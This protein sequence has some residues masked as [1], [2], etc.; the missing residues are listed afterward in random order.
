MSECITDRAPLQSEIDDHEAGYA[1]IKQIGYRKEVCLKVKMVSGFIMRCYPPGED[2]GYNRQIIAW[3][4][5]PR[6]YDAVAEAKETAEL[7]V[8]MRSGSDEKLRDCLH[9]KR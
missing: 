9:R 3:Q 8:A 7:L 1:T 2:W 5:P 4:L 6:P